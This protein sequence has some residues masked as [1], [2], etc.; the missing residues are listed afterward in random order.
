[1]NS[2]KYLLSL[3]FLPLLV[4]ALPLL[5]GRKWG[6]RSY[7]GF[8]RFSD[9]TWAFLH[10]TILFW[11]GENILVIYCDPVLSWRIVANVGMV[12]FFVCYLETHVTFIVFTTIQIV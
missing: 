8:E 11:Q 10:I 2:E 5:K 1:M 4:T 3:Y 9:F 12:I 6:V 7:T